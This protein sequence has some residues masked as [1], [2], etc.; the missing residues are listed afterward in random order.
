[1]QNVQNAA[2][3][4][5]RVIN[6]VE[7]YR[8]KVGK[9]S[10]IAQEAKSNDEFWIHE[11][12]DMMEEEGLTSAGLWGEGPHTE[13]WIKHLMVNEQLLGHFYAEVA[14]ESA[15]K[16]VLG[17]LLPDVYDKAIFTEEEESFLKDH[18]KDMVNYIILTPCDDS[19]ELVH[20]YDSK[21]HY[22]IPAEILKL[23][24]SRVD[25]ASGSKVY[26][27]NTA[28]AQLA[29]LFGGCTF[30][31]D[32][33]FY[34]WTK[35]ALYANNID[36]EDNANPSSFDAI[37]SYLPKG[38]DD[39]KAVARLCEAFMN[40][41]VGGKLVLICPPSVLVDEGNTS[42]EMT[43]SGSL[44]RKKVYTVNDVLEEVKASADAN[45]KFRQMLIEDNAIKEIIQLPQVMSTNASLVDYCLLIAEKSC[46]ESEVTFIDARVATNILNTKHYMYSFDNTKFNA[47]IENG[48][49]DPNTGLRLM[50]KVPSESLSKEL[51]V[52]QVYTIERPLEAEKPVS[53]SN[54]CTI[55]STLVLDVQYDLPENT[56]W[57]S[58]SDL[59][60]LFT[61]DMKISS[62]KK[63]NCPNNPTFVEGCK[64]Y[65]FN[66]EGK[67]V[68]SIWAQMNTK[69]GQYVLEYRKC[70]FLD[71]NNDAVLYECSVKYGV[72]VAVVRA[73]GK[74]YAVSS[75]IL[76]LCPKDDFDANS[77]AAL[78]RLPIVYRQLQVYQEYGI[79]SY[80]GDIL[81]PTSKRVIG[82]EL[83]RMKKE[84]SVTNELGDKV[85]AMKTEYINE[86]RMRKHDMRPHMKQL[87]SAKNLM[88]HYVENIDV[89][90]NVQEHLN[91]QL[92]RFQ[93]ALGH[94]SDIIEHLSDEELFGEP[95]CFSIM[96]Y[97]KKLINES[98]NYNSDVAFNIDADAEI[99]LKKKLYEWRDHI[100]ASTK[101][102]DQEFEK[103]EYSF[104]THWTYAN[105]A[106]LD[107]DRMVQNILENARK[108]GF[109]D[110]AR[111][112]YKVWIILGVD[113][114]RDMYVIDFKNNGT[115]LPEGMTKE[116]YG[117]KGEKAG[118][119]GGTGSG[120]Y[121]VRSIVTHYG[122]DY[123]VFYNDENQLTTVRVY[124]PIAT[125]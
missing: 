25:I 44:K 92:T 107:F 106:P 61:G 88:Q 31:C 36:A 99:Y 109:T 32:S 119:N 74:P 46:H 86:V 69:K 33:M 19:L 14:G 115:P 26:Y 114:K 18:F 10:Q 4:Q 110:S 7:L 124:L 94:L 1:M 38:D 97:F 20:R 102:K 122:G 89:T 37:V 84:E 117:I 34:A 112:D 50:L 66:K 60:P 72:R 63:A 96:D 39:S 13:I 79:G 67:F 68:D 9:E 22:T 70:T 2:D 59:T 17:Q 111:S 8:T 30:Y 29:N 3:I 98:I 76:V 91:R 55:E 82:D 64:D 90:E 53:L 77:L 95:E 65:A 83:Y 21:D 48:G 103:G 85:Q 42:N 113:E 118:L 71:G 75:G 40:L 62:V 120:G 101:A 123:D 24:K 80:L 58:M 93:D 87:N 41:P 43:L 125:I 54:L 45:S 35:V 47:L 78:L 23:I 51:L 15:E 28:F 56:P 104:P 73:T 5:Q 16:E 81:A 100:I 121:I 6:L 27:P 52:P 116:R 11:T 57:I 105:I 108:H 49:M 12:I